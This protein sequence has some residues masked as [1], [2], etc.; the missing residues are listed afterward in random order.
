MWSPDWDAP[1]QK[2]HLNIAFQKEKY[3]GP[4]PFCSAYAWSL[5]GVAPKQY[6]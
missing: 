5:S 1:T 3:V 4:F 2:I 6:I